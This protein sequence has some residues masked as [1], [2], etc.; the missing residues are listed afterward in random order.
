MNP[1]SGRNCDMPASV[2][3]KA[4]HGLDLHMQ[5]MEHLA[6]ISPRRMLCIFDS[7]CIIFAA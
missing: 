2:R 3:G 5:F 1:G 7:R 4:A 6:S